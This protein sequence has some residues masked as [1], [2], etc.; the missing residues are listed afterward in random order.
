MTFR[1]A[2]V[3]FD[4]DGTLVDSEPCIAEAL[5]RA[6]RGRGCP[7]RIGELKQHLGAPLDAVINAVSPGLHAELVDG[8]AAD[9]RRHYAA[10]EPQLVSLFPGIDDALEELRAFGTRMAIATNKPTPGTRSTVARLG[11]ADRIEVIVGADQVR[12][13]KPA[14]DM[15]H[16]VLALTGTPAEE[17]LVVGDTVFDLRM[18]RE[19]GIASCGVTWGNEAASALSAAGASYLIDSPGKLIAL[20][21]GVTPPAS[22]AG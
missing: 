16:R 15:A 9:Y 3:I 20:R 13:P 22:H 10:L 19:A 17:A 14:P 21:R 7:C 18:A 1:Y 12:Q 4:F 8:V 6:L 2:L 5:E 11:L